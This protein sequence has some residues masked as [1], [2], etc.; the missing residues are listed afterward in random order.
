MS[1][2][3]ARQR[4]THELQ[5]NRVVLFMK[6]TAL[7]PRCGFSARVGSILRELS[8]TYRDIDVLSEE[9]IREEIKTYSDWPTFPQ[10]YVD[11][12]FIG[13]CDIVSDLYESGELHQLLGLERPKATDRPAVTITE[14]AAAEVRKASGSDL[15]KLRFDIGPHGEYDLYFDQAR[16]GDV[17]I[18]DRGI[19]MLVSR[20]NASQVNGLTIDFVEDELKSGFRIEKASQA[21]AVSVDAEQ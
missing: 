1:D 18:S 10:L 13:G 16:P 20:P 11:G 6:G 2:Q 8:V 19:E 12:R 4:I 9:A 15:Q 3:A 5:D 7:E 14:R 17:E 21:S